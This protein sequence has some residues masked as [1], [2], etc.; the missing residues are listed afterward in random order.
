MTTL[1]NNKEFIAANKVELEARKYSE[2]CRKY[3]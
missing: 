3:R 1:V 2:V